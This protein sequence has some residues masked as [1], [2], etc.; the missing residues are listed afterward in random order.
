MVVATWSAAATCSSFEAN[1]AQ[2]LASST[3]WIPTPK[4]FFSTNSVITHHGQAYFF[5]IISAF[6]CNFAK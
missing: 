2:R 5:A 4:Y 6:H 1:M 3:L